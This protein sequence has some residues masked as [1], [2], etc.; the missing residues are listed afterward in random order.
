MEV[1]KV[2]VGSALCRFFG[3]IIFGVHLKQNTILLGGLDKLTRGAVNFHTVNFAVCDGVKPFHSYLV[4][5]EQIC[6]SRSHP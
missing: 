5:G 3:G 2:E 4:E 6:A 1:A